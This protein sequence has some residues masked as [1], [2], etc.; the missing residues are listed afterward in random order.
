MHYFRNF[1][2]PVERCSCDGG[3]HKRNVHDVLHSKP[4][5]AEHD[6]IVFSQCEQIHQSR[7]S[8]R[9]RRVHGLEVSD[10]STHAVK[11]PQQHERLQWPRGRLRVFNARKG[12]DLCKKCDKKGQ[13]AR[14]RRAMMAREQVKAKVPSINLMATLEIVESTVTEHVQRNQQRRVKEVQE[15]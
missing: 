13:C 12:A 5:R 8:A 2:G 1:K 14:D 11:N 9:C 7:R 3:V 4:H 6:P 10:E 15:R